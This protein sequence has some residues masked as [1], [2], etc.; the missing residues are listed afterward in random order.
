MRAFEYSPGGLIKALYDKTSGKSAAAITI[1]DLSK[2]LTG[3]L[4]MALGTILYNLG[5]IK[6]ERN[7]SS[8][9][10]GLLQEAGEQ[11]YSITTPLGS[12]T[13]DWAQPFSVPLAMGVSVAET[14][15]KQE[16]GDVLGALLES[17]YAGGDTIF[18]MTMLKNIKD[19]LGSSG[20]PTE[21]LLGIPVAYIEQAIPSVFGQIAKTI[22]PTRRSTYDPNPLKQEWNKI[23]SK[24]PFA[25]QAL[26]PALNLWGDEQQQGGAIQQFFSP[27]YWKDSS[28]DVVTNEVLRIYKATGN[29]DMLP[30]TA[31]NFT[32]NGKTVTL[33]AEL[34]TKFQRDMGQMNYNDVKMLM[35]S[36]FYRTM[37]DEARAK[38]IKKRI[39][40]NYEAVKK[41]I[42]REY[43]LIQD[44]ALK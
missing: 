21:K 10:E 19:I 40:G 30:K 8:K 35:N 36:P 3:T 22:D 2:G 6:V 34:M 37:D 16:K 13:F 18:N 38:Q 32:V 1:E 31:F 42:L 4:I 5:W 33:P 39:D 41:N 17:L 27:G 24:L 7:R 25:S 20:S 43:K 11:P 26:E 12:F 14:F 28:N 23:A 15:N 29:T 9:A 44:S